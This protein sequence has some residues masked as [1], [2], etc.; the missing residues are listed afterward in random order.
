MEYNVCKTCGAKNGRA[1]LLINN[2]CMNC[3]DTRKTGNI[4]IHSDLPRTDE[5]MVKIFAI[6]EK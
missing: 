4:T 3:H 5:E 1:G 2:E 6:L